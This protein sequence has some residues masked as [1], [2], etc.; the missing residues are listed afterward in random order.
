MMA[1]ISEPTPNLDP[2]TYDLAEYARTL[3]RVINNCGD[4][5]ESLCATASSEQLAECQALGCCSV[6]DIP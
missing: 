6:I 5:D 4:G 3:C 2:I 1:V